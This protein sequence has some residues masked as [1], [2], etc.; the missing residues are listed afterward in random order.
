MGDLHQRDLLEISTYDIAED[1]AP[2][3]RVEEFN[4]EVPSIPVPEV[5]EA[6]FKVLMPVGKPLFNWLNDVLLTVRMPEEANNVYGLPQGDCKLMIY[7]HGLAFNKGVHNHYL[8]LDQILA[9]YP[10]TSAALEQRQKHAEGVLHPENARGVRRFVLE[11]WNP[12]SRSPVQL[13][14]QAHRSPYA[15]M[16]RLQSIMSKKYEIENRCR[17]VF[18]VFGENQT[19]DAIKFTEAARSMPAYVV[20]KFVAEVTGR[21]ADEVLEEARQ[22]LRPSGLKVDKPISSG[23]INIA[24]LLALAFAAIGVLVSL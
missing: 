3:T 10:L 1:E 9:V 8:S 21:P 19:A 17:Y 11:Y 20:A 18:N 14:L 16:M 4:G 13:V 12:V 23:W 7:S 22:I 2:D 24:I 6:R 15:F 5:D